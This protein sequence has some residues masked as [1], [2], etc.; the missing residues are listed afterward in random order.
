MSKSITEAT[1]CLQLSSHFAWKSW[2]ALRS[3]SKLHGWN[4]V[5]LLTF[6]ELFIS[7]FYPLAL[8]LPLIIIYIT[9]ISQGWIY[10][11]LTL[12]YIPQQNILANVEVDVTSVLFCLCLTSILNSYK[13]FSVIDFSWQAL[14]DKLCH[15]I[16]NDLPALKCYSQILCGGSAKNFRFG[17]FILIWWQTGKKTKKSWSRVARTYLFGQNCQLFD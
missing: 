17:Y 5:L 3:S 2:K 4:Q 6:P 11:S 12:L 16:I 15:E 9:S 10:K 8:R 13:W 7:N 14:F 1:R